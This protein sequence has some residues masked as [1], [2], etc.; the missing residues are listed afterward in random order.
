M[1]TITIDNQKIEVPEGTTVL[2]AARK[3]GIQIPTLCDHPHLTPFGG[4]RL[5]M[6][7]IEGFRTLQSACTVPVSNNMTVRTTSEQIS[8]ARKFVLTLIFSERNHFCPYCQVSGGDCELQNAAYGEGMTHWSLQPNWQ[9]Y[10][11]DASHPYII[12][13]HNRCILCRRCIR[14]CSELVGINTLGVEE[15]GAKTFVIA[16]LNVPLGESTCVSCGACVQV[17]PTGAII[18][19]RSA[20]RGQGAE[21]EH[22]FSVCVGC[23]LGCGIDVLTRDD[24]VVRIDGN[25]DAEVNGGILCKVGR[26]LPLHDDRERINTPMLR[27]NGTLQPAT[28]EEALDTIAKKLKSTIGQTNSGV[29]ALASTRLPAESLYLFKQLFSD[30]FKSN[31]VT[32]LEEGAYTRLSTEYAAQTGKP[33]EGSLDA[34][35]N[36]D[37][38]LVFGADLLNNHEVAGFMT[39][40]ILPNGAN[41]IVVDSSENK[42]GVFARSS[43][44]PKA[45][46]EKDLIQGLTAAVAKLGQN[47]SSFNQDPDLLVAAS[48]EKCAVSSDLLLEAAFR[49]AGATNPV[50][51]I[52]PRRLKDLETLKALVELSQTAGATL[53]DLKGGANSLAAAQYGLDQ[54][55]KI[56]GHQAAY[57]ALA[58]DIPSERMVKTLEDVPFLIV[59]ASHTSKLSAQADVILPVVNW[60]EQ[61]GHYLSMDGRIQAAVPALP[62]NEMVWSN[63]AVLHDLA[64]R[65]GISLNDNWKE[66]LNQRPSPVEMAV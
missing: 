7:E 46:T 22:T 33:F 63:S 23:S 53:I 34:L 44:A 37:S 56:N 54:A 52:D 21:V 61:E 5:C 66:E 58:D 42:M 26:F 13:E 59:Q 15:R 32:S 41:L 9:R 64:D 17:C 27:K 6:I 60:L 10:P 2:N 62:V 36:S 8:T 24:Q 55:F 50:I 39:R 12:L 29:A 14:A 31:M 19:R 43:L 51:I 28:W 47:K 48:A 16:D 20:Y 25:W 35:Y 4:C 45:G 38:V 1:V 11:V 18:D 3:A 30:G 49:F 57:V 40:R 65:L